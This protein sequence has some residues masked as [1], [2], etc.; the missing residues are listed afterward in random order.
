LNFS[1]GRGAPNHGKDDKAKNNIAITH[2]YRLVFLYRSG[3]KPVY[4]ILA[5]FGNA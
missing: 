3:F 4:G 1:Q 5:K 2:I